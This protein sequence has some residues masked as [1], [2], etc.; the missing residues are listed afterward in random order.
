M[1]WNL[2]AT[3]FAGLGAAGIALTLR[4]LS[5]KTLPKWIIP[6]FAGLGMLGYQIYTEYTWYDFKREQLLT[7]APKAEVVDVQTGS[8]VWR[9]WTYLKP[10]VVGFTVVDSDTVSSNLLDGDQVVEF[11][12][13][14][15]EKSYVDQVSPHRQL[16][17]CTSREMLEVSEQRQPNMASLQTLAAADPLYRYLCR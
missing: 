13:Y 2:V 15:F 8:M 4:F 17:N 16:L 12:L 7:Q 9:P 3:I 10:M 5:R 6:A 14:Q 1:I 11:V